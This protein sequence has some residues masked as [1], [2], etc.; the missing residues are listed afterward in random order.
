MQLHR[1]E[2]RNQTV[3]DLCVFE[4]AIILLYYSTNMFPP[5]LNAPSCQF[6]HVL[7]HKHMRAYSKIFRHFGCFTLSILHVLL[8]RGG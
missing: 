2:P 4:N 8:D 6:L 7:V 3:L 5:W 1:T